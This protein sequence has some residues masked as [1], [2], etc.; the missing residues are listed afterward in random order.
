MSSSQL[1]HCENLRDISMLSNV[2]SINITDCFR[3]T[4]VQNLGS[5]R[6][7]QLNNCSKLVSLQRRRRESENDVEKSRMDGQSHSETSKPVSCHTRLQDRD[8]NFSQEKQEE[9]LIL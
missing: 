8:H 3:I 2:H 1:E 6:V 5:V 9:H 4:T 7:I